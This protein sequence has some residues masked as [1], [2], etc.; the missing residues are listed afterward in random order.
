MMDMIDVEEQRDDNEWE[1]DPC[2]VYM[3]HTV[4][5]MRGRWSNAVLTFDYVWYVSLL[6]GCFT[7][8]MAITCLWKVCVVGVIFNGCFS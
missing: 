1:S 5:A 6:I 8:C 3:A 2:N 4:C 7:C